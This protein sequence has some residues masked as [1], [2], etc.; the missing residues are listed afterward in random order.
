MR[1]TYKLLSA[2]CS[3]RCNSRFF[4]SQFWNNVFLSF[5]LYFTLV[6]NLSNLSL[7]IVSLDN[8]PLNTPISTNGFYFSLPNV[9]PHLLCMQLLN[10]LFITTD[11]FP[12]NIRV[13]IN[14]LFPIF[15]TI[16]HRIFGFRLMTSS[17]LLLSSRRLFFIAIDLGG[18][19]QQRPQMSSIDSSRSVTSTRKSSRI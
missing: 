7:L 14:D 1:K 19:H 13:S 9:F 17:P 4:H 15:L 2:F 12:P 16:F 11:N 6:T 3:N 5:L 10:P 8:F 18:D